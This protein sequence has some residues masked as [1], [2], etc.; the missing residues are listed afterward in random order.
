MNFR[1]F[2]L[3]INQSSPHTHILLRHLEH[4]DEKIFVLVFKA[5]FV[6]PR[7]SVCSSV[8]KKTTTKKPV[9][10]AIVANFTELICIQK[11]MLLQDNNTGIVPC[12]HYA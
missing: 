4:G 11:V 6:S 3:P 5:A 9:N 12:Y 1:G 7:H 10:I 8:A 2:P